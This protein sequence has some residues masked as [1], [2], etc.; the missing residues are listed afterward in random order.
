MEPRGIRPDLARGETASVVMSLL[1]DAGALIEGDHFVYVS[2][3]HGSGWV[4]KDRL[5]PDTSIPSLLGKLLSARIEQNG[6]KPAFI[7]GPTTGG[8]IASMWIAHHTGA[9]ALF[10]EHDPRN[11]D[12]PGRFVLR[13]GFDRM[14]QGQSVLAVDDIVNTGHSIGQ[15]LDALRSAGAL[16]V[17]AATWVNRG[18]VDAPSL[19]VDHFEYLAEIDLPSWPAA[20]C[21]LCRQGVPI[22]VEF[23]H[24]AEYVA[25][26]SNSGS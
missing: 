19:G 14:V 3:D 21:R 4:A 12:S 23:A 1:R 9:R 6:W 18:R 2:G 11:E 22:N 15:T 25:A 20:E 26:N 24:G 10:T 5:F 17:G 13:R 7:C 16:I 8:L